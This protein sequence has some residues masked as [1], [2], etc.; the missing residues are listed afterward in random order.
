MQ[1]LA[2]SAV[3]SVDAVIFDK[4]GTLID[5]DASWSPAGIRFVEILSAGDASLA[6]DLDAA[7]GMEDGAV[8]PNGVLA[9]GTLGDLLAAAGRVLEIHGV[10]ERGMLLELARIEASAVA[11]SIVAP[12]GDVAAAVGRLSSAGLRLGVTTSD[13]RAPTLRT[14]AD[15]GLTHLIDVV[16]AGDEGVRP[17]PAPDSLLTA[18]AHLGVA[19]ARTLYV[20]DS[21]VDVRAARAAGTAGFVA[22]G[23]ADGPAGR[24]ADGTMASIEEIVVV[25]A[26]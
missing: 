10:T 16:V 1:I 20:G 25:P 22:V 21:L 3:F 7:L 9:A 24:E 13:D 4:D 11:S 19:I 15:L 2:G 6:A 14:L 17:K 12:I 5:L 23:P 26:R 8:I 18:A